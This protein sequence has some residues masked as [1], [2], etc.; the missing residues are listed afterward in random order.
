MRKAIL[1]LKKADSVLAGIIEA[2]GPYRIEYHEPVF[3]T[4]ARSIIFQ[5]LSGRVAN[6]IFQRLAAAAGANA[7]L[8]P[9]GILALTPEQLRACGLSGQKTRYLRD[10]AERTLAGHVR[11]DHLPA[12]ADHEVTE[13][14]TQVKGVGVWTTHMFLMFALRRPDVLPVGDLGIRMAMKRAYRMRQLPKP[15]RMEKIARKWHP[16]CSVACWYLWRSLENG[17][18]AL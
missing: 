8:T 10:L 2:V 12:L 18:A 4:L 6:V 3:E 14:L 5:Q 15:E 7:G 11:F 16:W 13:H 17:D 9:E 1:H